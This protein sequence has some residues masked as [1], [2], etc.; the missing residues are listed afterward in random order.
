MGA[1]PL[2]SFVPGEYLFYIMKFSHLE[3]RERRSTVQGQPRKKLETLLEE[4]TKS[5]RRK[6]WLNWL[7]S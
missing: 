1:G 4:K 2:E 6:T 3:C 7:A 5:K